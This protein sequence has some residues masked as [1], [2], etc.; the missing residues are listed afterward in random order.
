MKFAA[1]SEIQ[2]QLD[3]LVDLVTDGTIS[4]AIP[5]SVKQSH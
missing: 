1:I 5:I 3:S 4:A 2:T